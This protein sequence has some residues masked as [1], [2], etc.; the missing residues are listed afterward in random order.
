MNPFARRLLTRS[1]A[2]VPAVATLVFAGEKSVLA[3]L[4][5]TQIVLSL[6]LPFA[7][8]P[9]LRFTSSPTLMGSF[10]S[11]RVLR[12]AG[13]AG[14][15]LVVVANGW[16]LLYT[17]LRLDAPSYRALAFAGIGAC[18]AFL[19]FVAIRPL[20]NR[21][22]QTESRSTEQGKRRLPNSVEAPEHWSIPGR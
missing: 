19:A 1:I 21:D 14:A 20:R 6:Q 13:W 5:T 18:A 4:V 15:S 22:S 11:G 12:I 10:A 3:L 8:V 16:L 9:L 7:I 2:V 17:A